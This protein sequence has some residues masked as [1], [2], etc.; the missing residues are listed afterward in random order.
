VSYLQS[1]LLLTVVFF[2]ALG[3][4][5]N[6][7]NTFGMLLKVGCWLMALFGSVVTLAALGIVLAN[8]IKLV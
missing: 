2:V 4:M 1:Y 8:G 5:L 6:G 3:V 7:N